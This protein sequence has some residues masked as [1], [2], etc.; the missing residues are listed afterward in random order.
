M[1]LGEGPPAPADGVEHGSLERRRQPLPEE[2]VEAALRVA[3]VRRQQ[4]L[5]RKRAE[6]KADRARADPVVGDFGHLQAPAAHVADQAGRVV[7]AR[8]DAQ[9]CVVRLLRA[10]KNTHREPGLLGDRSDQPIAIRC[11]ADGLGGDNFDP[12]NVHRIGDSAEPAHRL[13]RAPEA[14]GGELAR[15]I[16]P[17]AQP[18]QRLLVEPRERRAAEP[19]VDD[20]PDRVGADVHDS[21]VRAPIAPRPLGIE[22]QR[23]VWPAR[24]AVPAHRSA[25]CSLCPV[26]PLGRAR[27]PSQR[28]LAMA[29]SA[30]VRH[31]RCAPYRRR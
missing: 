28:E 10:G 30:G 17:G 7:E 19:V 20:E 27:P 26:R 31:G 11:A 25:L 2:R 13:D 8:D 16:E 3:P 12:A 23:A 5:H 9:R 6:R 15:L 22:H 29:T 14:L 21:E 18:A 4:G 24:N 1:H